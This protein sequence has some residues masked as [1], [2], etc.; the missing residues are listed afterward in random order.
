MSKIS[1]E[2]ANIFEDGDKIRKIFESYV[3]M[4]VT[5]AV[6]FDQDDITHFSMS[7]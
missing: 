7:L 5:D 2:S 1:Y 6:D 4:V 3:S